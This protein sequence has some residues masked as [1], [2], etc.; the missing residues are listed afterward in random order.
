MKKVICAVIF[1]SNGQL[2]ITRRSKG[3]YK[4][5]WEFPGGKVEGNESNHDCLHRELSEELDVNVQI[6]YKFTEFDYQYPSHGVH[7]ISYI[8][9]MSD[10]KIKL[11]DH[12]LHEWIN[13]SD[14]DFFDFLSADDEI[15]NKL[16]NNSDFI[17]MKISESFS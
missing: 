5:K 7:L 3:K 10:Q 13:I 6:H 2:L 9:S 16:K 1:N 17:L 11:V 15:L 8:C 14:V 4:D 12:D